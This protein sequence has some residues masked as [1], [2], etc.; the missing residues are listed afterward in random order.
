MKMQLSHGALFSQPFKVA[1]R[2][3]L[4]YCFYKAD[5]KQFYLLKKKKL[6][7]LVIEYEDN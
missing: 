1:K 3:M 6:H 5:I 2:K 4:Y 7:C